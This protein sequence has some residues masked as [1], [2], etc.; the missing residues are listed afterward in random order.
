MRRLALLGV[1]SIM[2]LGLAALSGSLVAQG[3]DKKDEQETTELHLLGKNDGASFGDWNVWRYYDGFFLMNTKTD[4]VV[5][6]PWTSNGWINYRTDKGKWY[7]LHA[8]GEAKEQDCSDLDADVKALLKKKPAA[9]LETGKYKFEG[10]I[11]DKGKKSRQQWNVRVARDYM[12]FHNS[13]TDD[14]FTI[15]RNSGEIVHNSRLIG[16]KE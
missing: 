14:R 4:Y 13:G 12:D 1:A 3:K 7:V 6:L 15:R 5:Y 11:D 16:G 9:T 8:K 10:I 2:I